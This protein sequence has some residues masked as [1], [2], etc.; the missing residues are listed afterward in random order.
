MKKLFLV[1][2]IAIA[3]WLNIQAQTSPAPERYNNLLE[4]MVL[5]EQPKAEFLMNATMETLAKDPKGYRMMMELAE[6][7][8]SDPADPLHN[9]QLYMVVLKHTTENFVLSNAEK[10]KQRLLL[11]G[12]KKNMIGTIAAD[13]D[14][15]TPNDKAV[16]HLKDLKA[17][18][19][20]VYFNNPDCE[21]CE[22]VKERL[23]NNELINN[24]VSEKK[25]I[26]LGIYPYDD[27]KLWKKSKYPTMMIN[28]WNQSRQIEYNELYDLP[29]LPCFYLLDNNYTVLIKNEGSL[30][31]VETRLKALMSA[32]TAG[33]APAP[34]P[35]A[36]DDP[37][38]VHCDQMLNYLLNNQYNELYNCL[39]DDLKSKT[40]PDDL[41]GALTKT[42]EMFG[43]YKGN[44]PW[45]IRKYQEYK[46]YCS[47]LNY[48]KGKAGL[49]IIFDE[50][51]KVSAVTF[52]PDQVIKDMPAY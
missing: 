14:Y 4:Q 22:T 49:I 13:F 42:E 41:N 21:S 47:I 31:K 2:V 46:T 37:N 38:F 29:T 15:V 7:R 16:H 35:K 28:G 10:E 36:K 43:K 23:A 45:E 5:L 17:D 20:L 39:T 12:A 18:Y 34:Q 30:N 8:F 19:I 50:N 44:E 3:G 27:Q 40:K 11:M 6:K 26:V 1:A 51:G 33:P 48:E 32:N 52:V 9:E 24:L 25:L